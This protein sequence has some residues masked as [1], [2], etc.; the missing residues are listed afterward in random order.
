MKQKPTSR[1]KRGSTARCR[2]NPLGVSTSTSSIMYSP[3]Q[4]QLTGKVF[5]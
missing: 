5:F 1:R 2:T 4:L 3:R